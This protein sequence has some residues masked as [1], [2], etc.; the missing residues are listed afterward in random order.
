M[1]FIKQFLPW[2]VRIIAKIIL[3]RLPAPYL[4]WKR[5]HL[6]EHGDM[7]EPGRAW[8]G[9]IE[10]ARAAGVLQ[11]ESSLPY[12]N[13]R[14]DFTVLELGPGDSL[15][16]ALIASTLGASHVWLVDAGAFATTDMMAYG[17]VTAFLQN[18]GYT[19]QSIG[20]FDNIDEILRACNCQYLTDGTKS[21][22]SIPSR[23]V[24]YCFSNAVLE[25]V[26]KGEFAEMIHE[27]FRVSKPGGVC[28]HRIDLKDHLGGGLNN[29][30]FSEHVWEGSL[31]RHSGFYTNRMRLMEM[32]A[33]FAGAGFVYT[34]LRVLRW[35]NLPISR[36]KLDPEFLS[37]SD[38]ELLVS[39]V[40]ILLTKPLTEIQ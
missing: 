15:F 5:L 21:L 36:A 37:F 26:P 18:R 2:W 22:S 3:A 31:F 32:L 13:V 1:N 6:F 38:E 27:L 23:T 11:D 29:L 14:D 16:S 19:I 8:A 28:L 17:E 10:H 40:D 4:F 9:F 35:E 34:L 33:I 39:G 30:R 20:N 7:N 24:D 12:L 25:H